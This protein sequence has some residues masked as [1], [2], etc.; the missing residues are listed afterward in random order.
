MQPLLSMQIAGEVQSGV[1]AQVALHGMQCPP[2]QEW[3]RPQSVA[4][5]QVVGMH[6]PRPSQTLP[7]AQPP[8]GL[9]MPL[10]TNAHVPIEPRTAQ[11]MQVPLQAVWQQAPCAQKP[12]LH[13]SFATHGAPNPGRPQVP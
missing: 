2:E 4:T 3:Y 6:C 11:D 7:A 1:D 9:G 8:F 5:V 12:L 10:A 13:S